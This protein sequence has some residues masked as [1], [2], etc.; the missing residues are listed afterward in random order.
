MKTTHELL[1]ELLQA[2]QEYHKVF[3]EY[4]K[5]LTTLLEHPEWLE[6]YL[7]VGKKNE[8][9]KSEVV[10]DVDASSH[11][12]SLIEPRM[13]SWKC[14]HLFMLRMCAMRWTKKYVN[15]PLELSNESDNTSTYDGHVDSLMMIMMII[16]SFVR[17]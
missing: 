16:V 5:N 11:E 15:T 2:S 1:A 12:G 13:T 7:L 8:R 17:T 14:M 9:F 4:Q 3:Q 10:G 6:S